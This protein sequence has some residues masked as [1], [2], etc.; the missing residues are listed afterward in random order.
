MDYFGGAP[1]ILE[2]VHFSLGRCLGNMKHIKSWLCSNPF[3][4]ADMTGM[5][6][7][8]YRIAS[9]LVGLVKLQH[10]AKKTTLDTEG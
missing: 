5:V 2:N 10:M 8:G 6:Y 1:T 7:G 9:F 4:S 3:I